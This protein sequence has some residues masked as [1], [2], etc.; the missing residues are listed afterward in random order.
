M[1]SKTTDQLVKKRLL[2][3]LAFSF[4]LVWIPTIV[5]QARG[6]GYESS[7]MQSI[8]AYSMLC[9][10][11]GMLFTRWMT[12]EGFSMKGEDSLKLGIDF[13][14][15]KWIWYVAAMLIPVVYYELGMLLFYLILPKSFD[16]SMPGELGIPANTVWMYP[17]AVITQTCMFSVGALGE[18]A[19]WRGYMMPKLEELFGIKR[20]ILIGGVIWGVWHFPA[21]YAGHNF[22]TDYFGAPWTGFLEFT[23]STIFMG[24]ILTY[25]TKKSGSVWP[26]A[27]LHAVNNGMPSILALY[28]REERLTGIW[29][30]SPVNILIREIPLFLMGGMAIAALC[31]KPAELP[32]N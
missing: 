29:A 13:S 24:A 26:A 5:F 21:I 23:L 15:K 30:Q 14:C 9:P 3:Y 2:I 8:L 1:K 25:L 12:G 27:F 10:S 22:G 28:C 7:A 11:I 31:R 18:E 16:P 19:G 4:L 32:K 17:I 20:A 6:G